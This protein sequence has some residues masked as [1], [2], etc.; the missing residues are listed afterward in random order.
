MIWITE[1]CFHVFL[2]TYWTPLVLCMISSVHWL[3]NLQLFGSVAVTRSTG[4]NVVHSL[5]TFSIDHV[6]VLYRWKR[7]VWSFS[8]PWQYCTRPDWS[9]RWYWTGMKLLH[10]FLCVRPMYY[11]QKHRFFSICECITCMSTCM[12]GLC[13]VRVCGFQNITSV[14]MLKINRLTDWP[15]FKARNWN[16]RSC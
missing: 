16:C 7:E 4:R 12:C 13:A 5:L 1:V 8:L 2:I 3:W 9:T 15:V 6:V 14:G 10:S 11:G